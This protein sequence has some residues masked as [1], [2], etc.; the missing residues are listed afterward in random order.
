MEL[1]DISQCFVG[2]NAILGILIMF[3]TIAIVLFIGSSWTISTGFSGGKRID[4]AKLKQTIDELR[5]NDKLSYKNLRKYYDIDNV[6]YVDIIHMPVV[7]EKAL[8]KLLDQ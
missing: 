7:T 2:A 8:S 1:H 6:T 3:A 4:V 5:A